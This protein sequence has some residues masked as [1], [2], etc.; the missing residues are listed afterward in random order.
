[1]YIIAMPLNRLKLEHEGR[2]VALN[3]AKITEQWRAIL[4]RAKTV[5]LRRDVETLRVSADF[6]VPPP[7]LMILKLRLWSVVI[8]MIVLGK[9]IYM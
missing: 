1:M 8:F 4:R 6:F 3:K 2:S 9:Y 5:D 7:L